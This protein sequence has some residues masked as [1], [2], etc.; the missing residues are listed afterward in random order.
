MAWVSGVIGALAAAGLVVLSETTR[1]RAETN[2]EGWK[3]L[4]PGWLTYATLTGGAGM[5]T[6]FGYIWLFVGS[7]RTDAETQM[8]FALGLLVTFGLTTFYLAWVC[9]ARTVMWKGNQLK[10]TNIF[11]STHTMSFGS[12]RRVTKN[13][14]LGLYRLSFKHGKTIHISKDMHGID[15]LIAKLPRRDF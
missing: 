5:A 13:D 2:D 8:L 1:R 6:L 3:V 9:L 12:I 7:S 11:G 4:R 10:A 15:Q 14:F